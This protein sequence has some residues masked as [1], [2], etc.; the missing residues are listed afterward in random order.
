MSRPEITTP[1][2]LADESVVEL[3]LRPQRLAEFIGQGKVKDALRIYI[4]AA[5]ARRS[6]STTR[7]SSARRASARPPWPS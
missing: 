3:S 4:D 1:E 5:T 7:S 2:S 6:R